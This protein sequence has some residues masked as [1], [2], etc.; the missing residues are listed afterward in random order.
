M[1]GIIRI[2]NWSTHFEN[3]RSRDVKNLSWV[4]VP[5]K[6][7]GDG[8]TELLD[9]KNGAAHFGAWMA[10]VQVASKCDVRGTLL[11]DTQKPHDSRSLSRITRI[12]QGTFDEVIPRLV[13]IGWIEVVPCEIPGKNSTPQE[14]AATPQEGASLEPQAPDEGLDWTGLDRTGLDSSCVEPDEPAS[15]QESEEGTEFVFPVVGD[16]KR[17]SWTLPASKL[18]E[19]R[20]SFPD[21]PLEAIL[22]AAVQWCRDNKPKRKTARGMNRFLNN[23]LSTAQNTSRAGPGS[24]PAAPKSTAELVNELLGDPK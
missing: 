22:R 14:G 3:N 19:Y 24:G 2:I 15:T 23:W 12:P 18:S 6:L 7:D 21:L 11:R 13:E 17:T 16:P 9:H 20:E 4:L 1:N 10:I 5:N 8:Y